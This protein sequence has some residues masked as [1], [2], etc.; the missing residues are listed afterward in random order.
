MSAT[1]HGMFSPNEVTSTPKGFGDYTT[2]TPV[3]GA[4]RTMGSTIS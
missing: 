3:P 4:N 2:I 1:A